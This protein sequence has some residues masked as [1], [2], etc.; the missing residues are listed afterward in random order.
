MG[1]HPPFG[2]ASRGS[3]VAEIV[4]LRLVVHGRAYHTRRQIS[5]ACLIHNKGDYDVQSLFLVYLACAFRILS[6]GIIT[7]SN[8]PI[9]ARVMIVSMFIAWVMW[10]GWA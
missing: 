7:V 3:Q 9:S 10:N 5:Q 1:Y 2:L 4:F 8:F 6:T